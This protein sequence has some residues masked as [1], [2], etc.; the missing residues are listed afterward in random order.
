MT[1]LNN[2]IKNTL[3]SKSNPSFKLTFPYQDDYTNNNNERD[4]NRHV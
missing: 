3:L 1:H 4:Q 2:P